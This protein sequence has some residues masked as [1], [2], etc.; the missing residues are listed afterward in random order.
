MSISPY[1]Q[2]PIDFGE[3]RLLGTKKGI[4]VYHKTLLLCVVPWATVAQ[5]VNKF[6]K[7]RRR[8]RSTKKKA[9]ENL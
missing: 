7:T 2:D 3:T 5:L 6:Y 4:E 9:E 1:I 8:A